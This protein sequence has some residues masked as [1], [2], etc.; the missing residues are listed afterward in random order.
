[1][2]AATSTLQHSCGLGPPHGAQQAQRPNQ[3]APGLASGAPCPEEQH[4]PHQQ[5]QHQ[6]HHKPFFYI[7]PSQPYLPMQGLQ[8]PV[9]MPMPVSYNPFYGYP[10]LGYGMPVMPHYQANP[11]IEPPGFVVPHT[12]LHLMDYRRM[13]NPQY[14]QTMAYHSRRLRYQRNGPTREMTSSEVQTEPVSVPQRTSTPGSSD[15]EAFGVLPACSSDSTSHSLSPVLAAQKGDHSLEL[16]DIVPSSTMP[17]NGSFVIQTEEVR[18]ECCTTPVGLQLLHSRETAEMSHRFSEDVVQCSSI[19]QGHVLQD[20][21]LCASS[22]QSEQA[23]QPCPDILLGGSSSSGEKIAALDESKNQMNPE[24]SNLSTNSGFEV[25]RSEKD[26][27][28]TSKGFDFK[29]V[30]LPFDPKYLNELQKMES[31]VWS[32][33]DTLVPSP[34]LLIQNSCTDSP[35]ETVLAEVSTDVLTMKEVA[36][37]DEVATIQLDNM[38]PTLEAPG[39]QKVSEGD[40]CPMMDVVEEGLAT[41]L[42]HTAEVDLAHNLLL[43]NSPLKGDGIKQRREANIQDHQDT[44]FESLPAYLPS[45]SWLADFDSVYYCSKMPPPKKQR[46]PQGNRCMDVPSQRRKLDLEYKKQPT[47]PKPRE[48][49]KPKGKADW[50]SLSD[51]EC[52]VSRGFNENS[53]SPCMSKMERLCS[54]CQ[55]KRR[56]CTSASPGLDGRSLKRKAAPFQQWND[57]LLPTCETCKSHNKRRLM[58]K[59]SNPDVRVSYHGNDTEGDSSENSTCR[60][61]QKWRAA[62]DPK[63]ADLKRPLACKQNLE[64]FPTAMF[65]K[66]REKNCAC[67]EQQ[68]QPAAREK[69]HHCPHSNAI[70]EMDENCATPVSF[71]D[72][73]RNKDP[74]YLT[75]RWQTVSHPAEK[76]WK[77]TIPNGS[78]NEARAQNKHK[79]SQSQ[80]TRRKDT[81]C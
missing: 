34:G 67:K 24:T 14:Y 42:T 81:R 77:A 75:H 50:R 80:G 40:I 25:T 11:C 55:A 57:A 17:Q 47:A 20:E 13:L 46:K 56:I 64:R 63:L 48:R 2:E 7:Q 69:L 6:Q 41:K 15:I 27:G 79:K 28:N 10:G 16:K 35:D 30:R 66:L 39:D 76:A 26:P 74:I 71:Q 23:L 62:E 68:H 5:Q 8:W 65:P 45:T 43:L 18:I 32:I 33:E 31:T 59:G 3:P 49:Y 54:R 53:F 38:V 37:T 44:S 78:N 9:P 72:K 19:L 12:H 58:R 1:M 60:T 22:E 51:H 4:R 73:W 52:C 36:P 61:G 29:V 70:R 21:G